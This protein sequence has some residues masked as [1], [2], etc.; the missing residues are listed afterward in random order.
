MLVWDVERASAGRDAR[1][2]RRARSPG[3]RSP[4]TARRCTP[5]ASTARSSI[6]DLARRPPPRPPVRG[7]RPTPTSPRFSL[8][9]D[10]RDLAIGHDDGTVTLI[11]ARTLRP[12]SS[13]RASREGRSR[14]WA[15]CPRGALLVVGGEN[16]F[17]ALVDPARGAEVK[18]L[19]GQSDT[20]FTPGFSADGRLHGGAQ[21]RTGPCRVRAAVGPAGRAARIRYGTDISDISLS[22][23]GRTLA[24][25]RPRGRLGVEILDV[26]RLRRRATLPDSETLWDFPRFTPDGRFLMGAS[27]KGWARLWSTETY[28]PVGRRFAGHA[29][30]V[31]WMSISPDG[32]TLATGSPDGT[33]RLWDLRTQQ[34]LGAPLPGLPNRVVLPQFTPDGAYLFAIYGD[35]RARVPLGRAPVLVGPA[36]LHGRRAAAHAGAVARRAAGPRLRPGRADRP[37][38]ARS[39]ASAAASAS[40]IAGDGRGRATGSS[41]GLVARGLQRPSAPGRRPRRSAR[42]ARRPA[43]ARCRRSRPRRRRPRATRPRR[44]AAAARASR[45]AASSRKEA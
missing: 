37:D 25:T 42:A 30:R 41:P 17:L 4:A 43:G 8:R 34:P 12:R 11:D 18:R 33:I 5:A 7:R 26:P 14:A 9:H 1:G 44:R 31:D 28:K 15:T 38:A 6:W 40:Y 22:P 3:W 35:A 36:R 21:R 10:G 39:R 20:V 45:S 2:P 27:W 19:P 13:F 24:L 16:G 23:D 32:D 29:G